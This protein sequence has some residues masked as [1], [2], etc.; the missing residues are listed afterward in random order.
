MVLQLRMHHTDVPRL[1]RT[2]DCT[3]PEGPA[4]RITG[5]IGPDEHD[6]D[7]H[8]VRPG[9]VRSL[10]GCIGAEG[11]LT[12]SPPSDAAILSGLVDVE[13]WCLEVSGADGLV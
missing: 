2:G 6:T 8:V 4:G 10:H 5:I 11:R 3:E 13:V 12:A 9:P 1:P 7:V